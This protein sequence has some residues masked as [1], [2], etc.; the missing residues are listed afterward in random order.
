MGMDGCGKG[1]GT[2]VP[3]ELPSRGVRGVAV[4]RVF[5]DRIGA[6]GVGEE[7]GRGMFSVFSFFYSF[8]RLVGLIR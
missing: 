6:R 4:G 3:R 1:W 5:R 8:I 7:E 2:R